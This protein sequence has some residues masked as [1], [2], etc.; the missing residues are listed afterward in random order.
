MHKII[1]IST[2]LIPEIYRNQ[3]IPAL[4]LERFDEPSLR[5]IKIR[6]YALDNRP[7][8]YFH[9]WTLLEERFDCDDTAYLLATYSEHVIAWRLKSGKWVQQKHQK[10]RMKPSIEFTSQQACSEIIDE[11]NIA[12]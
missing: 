11:E 6:G 9:T 3:I 1:G 12:R 7:C 8:F 5:A 10:D 4:R 2:E